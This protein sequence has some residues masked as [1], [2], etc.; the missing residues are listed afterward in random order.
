LFERVAGRRKNGGFCQWAPCAPNANPITM[1]NLRQTLAMTAL[2][3]AVSALLM[4]AGASAAPVYGPLK[5]YQGGIEQCLAWQSGSAAPALAVCDGGA[6]QDWTF[7]PSAGYYQIRNA[8]AAQA[9]GQEMC[10]RALAGN[11]GM[12]GTSVEPCEGGNEKMAQWRFENNPGGRIGMLNAYRISIGRD[13]VLAVSA[14]GKGVAMQ[15]ARGE[16]GALWASSASFPPSVRPVSGTKSALVMAA[17]FSDAKANDPEVIRKAV[18][19]DGDEYSSLRRYLEVAS[20][21]KATLTGTMLEDVDLGARPATCESAALVDSARKAA[22]AR[23]VDPARFDY[24]MVDFSK[25]GSCG[26]GGLAQTPGNWILSNGNGHGY[27]L[28]THEFGHNLAASH[29][30]SMIDCPTPGGTVEVGAACRAGKVDDPSDTVG[31]GGRRLYPGSYQMY[32]GWLT[33]SD[34]PEIRDAGTYRIAPLFGDKPGARGYRIARTDG[35]VLWLEFRQPTRGFDDWKS[36]DPFVN[37][38]I[39][40]TVKYSGGKVLNTLVDTT[41]GSA[42]GMK[43]APLMPGHALH[44]TLS[45]KIITVRSVGP[46]GAVVDVKG[47][48]LLLPEAAITGPQQ[49]DANATVTLSGTSSVGERLSYQWRAPAGITLK[50]AGGSASFVAPAA[51]QDRDYTFGLLVINDKGFTSETTHVVKVKA[52]EVVQPPR[53]AI[54]GPANVAGGERV[55]LSGAQSTGKGLTYAWT[56]LSGVALTQNGATASFA[57]PK[58][59]AERGYDFRLTVTD[60]LN[61]K[62]EAVHRVTVRADVVQGAPAWAPK[63]TYATPCEKVAYGG[64]TWMNGWWVQ[65]DVPGKG[66]EWGPW[67]EQG[68]ANMHGQCKGK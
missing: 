31:G 51:D 10:L 15:F 18:L 49:V 3:A 50:P 24:L 56:S 60:A 22:L 25:L 38:V 44:D 58:A 47:D 65:G 9:R 63:R 46:D 27:W 43:D 21:G 39:V 11:A 2:S 1:K 62:S 8:G 34:V 45:G 7:V 26:W 23:G 68:S 35:T 57:A 55:T 4:P 19:G 40:R 67:R 32:A 41:P 64:K 52:Q 12:G 14:D 30:G 29:P 16:P 66:G 42:D 20:H 48:G 6:A 54:S 53:A 37:G 33:E 13:E 28:W 5:I 59:E 17:R 61:R 36:N